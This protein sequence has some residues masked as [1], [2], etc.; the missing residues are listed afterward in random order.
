MRQI[1]KPL[2]YFGAIV[3]LAVACGVVCDLLMRTRPFSYE[4]EAPT[5]ES[6]R[7]LIAELNASSE[8]ARKSG[9]N[10][11]DRLYPK[12]RPIIVMGIQ[13]FIIERDRY[14]R[15]MDEII[16]TGTL[17]PDEL[18]YDFYVVRSSDS[19]WELYTTADVVVAK[20]N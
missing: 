17:N 18:T 7:Q 20:G 13:K 12:D 5:A 1:A 8:G 2:F 9:Y 16:N 19:G 4:L 3:V 14:P 11:P 6:R 10:D 15:S